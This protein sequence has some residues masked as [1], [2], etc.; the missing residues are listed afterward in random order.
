MEFVARGLDRHQQLATLVLQAKDEADASAQAEHQR[1][2]LLSLRARKTVPVGRHRFGLALFTHELLALLQAGL[3]IPAA[4]EALA[5]HA[6]GPQR[7][8][9]Q[10]LTRSLLEGAPL[11]SAMEALPHVFPVLLTKLVHAAE[12]SGSLTET[13]A[14]YEAYET[15]REGLRNKVITATIYP[16]ILLA[17][18]GAVAL[19]L[20]GYV[21]PRFAKVYQGTGRELPWASG[22]LMDLGTA[23][24]RHGP[25][26]LLTLGLVACAIGWRLH[27]RGASGVVSALVAA[28]P[29]ARRRV[30][31]AECAR[32]YLSLGLLLEGG[33]ALPQAMALC[34]AVLTPARQ[35]RLRQARADVE[36]G[37]R[38]STSL[39]RASLGTPVALRL[40]RVGEQSGQLGQMLARAAQFHD[41]ETSRW[42]ERFSKALEPV[43]MAAIG[44]VIGLVV[45]MLYLPIF[46]LAGSL[47]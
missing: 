21:V 14:R 9:L 39:G 8:I 32:L 28:L 44:L 19:F 1:L 25:E 27:A 5:E 36:A 12:S 33:I 6:T 35:G 43:L 37:E 24:G 30:E 40:V 2:T 41:E 42:I 38:L 20:V 10:R 17:V 45:V 46:D 31:T 23:V 47:Q 16:A 4:L 11:S 29:S 18:G 7:E 34:E 15:R 26:L 22:L 3:G 13:L